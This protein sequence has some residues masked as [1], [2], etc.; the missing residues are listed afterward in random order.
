MAYLGS[1]GTGRSLADYLLLPWNVYAQHVRFGTFMTTIEL[2]SL[3][4]P[5]AVL[6]PFFSPS[7]YL[8]PLTWLGLGLFVVWAAGS[9]QIRFLL[10]IFPVA[11][12][13]TA[14]VLIR[15]WRG[16]EAR[17]GLRILVPALLIGGIASTLA[18]QV[19]FLG[20]TRPLAVVIGRESKDSFLE[21]AVYDYR[22]LR[23]V[24]TAIPPG[25][26]VAML[27]DGQGYYCDP[28]CWPDADQSRWVQLVQAE[29]D[30]QSALDALADEGFDYVLVDYEGASFL[31]AHDP[32]GHHAR[33]FTLLLDAVAGGRLESAFASEKVTIFRIVE[34]TG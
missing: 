4:F 24:S 18:Y 12:V 10:P 9:Q 29:G 22:A 17:V 19:I 15:W 16:L 30:E 33:A 1:F 7:P 32:T 6:F 11:A 8:R 25:S 14:G 13:L 27:W 34:A 3:I 20:N 31:M 2:P 26:K 21:R 23:Y 5:L 28:R